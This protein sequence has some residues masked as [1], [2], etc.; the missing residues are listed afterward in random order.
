MFSVAIRSSCP[1]W[2]NWSNADGQPVHQQYCHNR[3]RQTYYSSPISEKCYW[4]CSTTS[5]NGK[6][7]SSSVLAVEQSHTY[8]EG[9]VPCYFQDLQHVAPH[10][11]CSKPAYW[12]IWVISE[13]NV[14]NPCR[15][16]CN[17]ISAPGIMRS[18]SQEC[19]YGSHNS[20][21]IASHH[22]SLNGPAT[23]QPASTF[24]YQ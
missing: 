20:L 13:E 16:C 6:H 22:C 2:N 24:T 15:K 10:W 23:L 11:L 9:G 12:L 8:R 19:I 7:D 21:L 4:S 18:S 17:W 1:V 3:Y 14:T 5:T